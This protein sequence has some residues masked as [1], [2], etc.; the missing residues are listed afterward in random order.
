MSDGAG[1]VLQ[2]QDFNDRWDSYKFRDM[3]RLFIE[4]VKANRQQQQPE[5]PPLAPPSMATLD[6]MPSVGILDDPEG[7]GDNWDHQ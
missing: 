4:G 2:A 5:A 3:T 7:D 6:W 1:L